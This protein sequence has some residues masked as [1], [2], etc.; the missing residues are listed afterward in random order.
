V[1]YQKVLTLL[2][3]LSAVSGLWAQEIKE[4]L[5]LRAET[6][7]KSVT[8]S[9]DGHTLAWGLLGGP[10][11]LS[12]PTN[13]K[14]TAQYQTNAAFWGSC[15]AFAPDGKTLYSAGGGSDVS[16]FDVPSSKER[17]HFL[18]GSTILAL[19]VAPNGRI[20]AA[21]ADDLVMLFDAKTGERRGLYHEPT[22]AIHALAFFPD[23]KK[24]VWGSE[25]GTVTVADTATGKERSSFKAD[26]ACVEALAISP[27][28][29]TLAV[30]CDKTITLWQGNPRTRHATLKGHDGH[31]MSIAFSP[32]GNRL[33]SA[34]FHDGSVRIW[35]VETAHQA[36]LLLQCSSPKGHGE[37]TSV[38]FSPDGT[39]LATA[40]S[41]L[42]ADDPLDGSV[43]IWTLP[44][45]SSAKKAK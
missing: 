25:R 20:V 7:V 18:F 1:R 10:I 9:P 2:T 38:A 13:G 35:D 43:K 8:F 42:T 30:A 24:L 41:E 5:R 16:V 17:P 6:V 3:V 33:A 31:I 14:L 39:K 45:R 29:K 27:D 28:A 22:G 15:L 40:G 4:S 11:Q 21:A 34:G 32:D 26:E 23:G 44:A 12:D 19:A 37:V 36:L